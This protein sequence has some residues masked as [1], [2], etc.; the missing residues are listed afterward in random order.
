[1]NNMSFVKGMGVGV[2]IGSAIGMAIA[3]RKSKAGA[4]SK[5]IKTVGDAV[6]NVASAIGLG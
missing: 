5:A 2:M 3:P 4:I 6:E 1:M